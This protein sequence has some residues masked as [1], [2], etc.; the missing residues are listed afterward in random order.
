MGVLIDCF[1]AWPEKYFQRICGH[2]VMSGQYVRYPNYVRVCY[3]L[4]GWWY[5]ILAAHDQTVMGKPRK[6]R[7]KYV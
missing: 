7:D 1:G 4:L 3:L 6:E 5:L 2:G